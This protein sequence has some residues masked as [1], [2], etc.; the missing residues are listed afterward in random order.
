M[1]EPILVN[2]TQEE[3]K[4][5]P[6]ILFCLC[7]ITR[8]GFKLVSG[9]DNFQLFGDSYRYNNISDR[10]IAGDTNM[11]ITAYLT[12]PL[13]P[14]TLALCKWVAGDNWQILAVS[15]QF[16]LVALSV[17]YIY[18]LGLLWFG[19]QR[20]AITGALIYIFYPLTLWYNFTL[21][22]ETSFQAYF[23]FFLYYIAKSMASG[24]NVHTILA[25]TFWAMAFLTKSHITVLIIPIAFIFLLTKRAKAFLIF[26]G[27]AIIWTLPH[28]IKNWKEHGVYT[29]SSHGNASLFLLGHS[30]ATYPCLMNKAGELGQ[31]AFAVCN[32]EIVFDREYNHPTYGL[33]NQL[34][35]KERNKMRKTI[36]IESVSY[37]HLTLPTKA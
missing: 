30:D 19:N 28:G 2:D 11:D 29:I 17:V 37:T 27:V 8:V 5:I 32:P 15:F 21:A 4:R 31:F 14:Y 16:I 25:A 18:K 22:Q 7:M 36:A 26:A 6:L 10:I 13:Y 3:N 9:F 23:V 35:V 34:S 20:V 33:I 12:A 24:K 1:Q